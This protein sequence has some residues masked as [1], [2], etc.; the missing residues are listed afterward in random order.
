[1]AVVVAIGP[2]IMDADPHGAKEFGEPLSLC[3][4]HLDVVAVAVLGLEVAPVF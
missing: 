2:E 4:C 3:V 1:M